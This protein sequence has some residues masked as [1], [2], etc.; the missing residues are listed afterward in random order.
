MLCRSAMKR[1]NIQNSIFRFA[2]SICNA[3][4][5]LMS[6]TLIHNQLVPLSCPGW[7]FILQ[8]DEKIFI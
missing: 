7:R 5:V 4:T 3:N 8:G 6:N 1:I 2:S